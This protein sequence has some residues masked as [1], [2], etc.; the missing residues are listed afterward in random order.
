V[1]YKA[2]IQ[3]K[4]AETNDLGL[5]GTYADDYAELGA[6][7][8]LRDQYMHAGARLVNARSG[9]ADVLRASQIA[10]GQFSGGGGGAIE[11]LIAEQTNHINKN[12][13]E[14]KT[15]MPKTF[16]LIP[17]LRGQL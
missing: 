11:K 4:Y 1:E 3:K 2:F 5:T 16:G 13:A 8:K 7:E 6:K 14:A 10:T 12:H 17:N 15:H 9:N